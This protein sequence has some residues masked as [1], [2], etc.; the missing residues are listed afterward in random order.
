VKRI[1]CDRSI[2]YTPIG[3]D[4]ERTDGVAVIERLTQQAA[5]IEASRIRIRQIREEGR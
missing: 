5:V 3:D 2:V 1:P 4:A